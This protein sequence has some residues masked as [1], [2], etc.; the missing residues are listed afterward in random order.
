MTPLGIGE[1]APTAGL[2][3]RARD[4]FAPRRGP[5]LEA[6]ICAQLGLADI[7]IVETGTA[8]LYIAL[9]YLKRQSPRRPKV[10]IPAYTC[11][12]VVRM[13][14]A[15]G[16]QAVPCDTV[17]GG[18]DLDLEDL[19]GL[20]DRDT[21]AVL[22]THYGG[23]LTDVARLRAVLSSDISIVEDAAQAFGATQNG[24]SVGRIGD[25]GVFSFGVGK[26]F[27]IYR[28]G[29]L[30]AT[31]PEIMGGLR[32]VAIELTSRSALA[33]A[34]RALLLAG[35]HTLYNPLGLRAFYGA[36]KRF[37]LARGD[38]IRAAG[39][40]VPFAVAIPRVGP[41]R[42]AVGRA[43]LAR[44]PAHLA[45]SRERFA[46]LC[47]NLGTVPGLK[48][49]LPAPGTRPT[50]TFVFVTLPAAPGTDATIRRLWASRLGVAKMFSRS[51]V[52]Y[53]DLRPFVLDRPTPHA[54]ALAAT[55]ITLSTHSSFTPAAEAAVLSELA[56]LG[57]APAPESVL[58]LG[59]R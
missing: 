33:E 47:Q 18:F 24:Q 10:I 37:W 5:T 46:Q 49:H 7:E 28:G 20:V 52:D 55:A 36:R 56:T 58:P 53:P 48:V 40:D 25:I 9:T 51:I 30:I 12:L 11:P 42:K 2:A 17:A 23:L 19:A 39:D 31:D 34:W 27:T 45:R 43:A 3:P 57:Q 29:G 41:W 26:G 44:M 21:L 15:T 59:V 16:L 13:I 50:A 22:P 4:L 35:Y 6:A 38:E 8:A 14:A 1:I 32:A 54:R